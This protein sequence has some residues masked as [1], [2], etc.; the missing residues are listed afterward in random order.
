[1]LG[2]RLSFAIRSVRSSGQGPVSAWVSLQRDGWMGRSL[3]L[4]F[5]FD[6]SAAAWKGLRHLKLK[7][8]PPGFPLQVLALPRGC[9]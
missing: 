7:A 2:D 6:D 8:V 4:Q 9:A 3:Q 1:M 5:L